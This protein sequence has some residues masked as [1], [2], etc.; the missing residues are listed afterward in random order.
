MTKGTDGMLIRGMDQQTLRIPTY[1]REVFDIPGA[2][3]TSISCLTVGLAAGEP[4][5]RAAKFA[6]IAA[7]IIVTKH[8]IAAIFVKELLC[9][10]NGKLLNI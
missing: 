10:E 7:G 6:N 3:D 8:G 9:A 5:V 4:L 2:G 1:S